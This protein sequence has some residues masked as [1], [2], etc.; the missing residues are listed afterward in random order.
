MLVMMYLMRIMRSKINLSTTKKGQA[1]FE[2]LVTYGW[3]LVLI[4]GVIALLYANVFRPEFYVAESCNMAPGTGCSSFYLIRSGDNM[5]LNLTLTNEMDFTIEPKEINITIK[6]F[7]EPGD[8]T[9]TWTTGAGGGTCTGCRFSLS[10]SSV[11]GRGSMNIIFNFTI[12]D[13][14]QTPKP[15]SLQRMKFSMMYNITET[16]S[17]HRTAGILNVKVS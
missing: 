6:D 16:N 14:K 11:I 13:P 7:L 3:A 4:F 2:Y 15:A 5:L 12:T 9:Y 1:A 10:N 17:L 8:K